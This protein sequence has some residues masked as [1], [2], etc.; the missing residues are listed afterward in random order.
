MVER[1]IYALF[2]LCGIV[3]CYYLILWV[4][5]QIGLRIPTE[6]ARIVMVMLILTAILVLWRLFG[7]ANFR[8]WPKDPSTP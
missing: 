5:D 8:L 3:L 4:L 7:S 2:Y 6:V 1:V